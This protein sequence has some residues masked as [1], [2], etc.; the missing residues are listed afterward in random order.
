MIGRSGSN[1][2]MREI[3]QEAKGQA[4]GQDKSK[5]TAQGKPSHERK[6]DAATAM[7]RAGQTD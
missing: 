6:Q 3:H 2:R 1:S 4:K 5:H 7:E